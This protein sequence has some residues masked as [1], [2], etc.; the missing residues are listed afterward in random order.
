[1]GKYLPKFLGISRGFIVDSEGKESKQLDIIIFDANKAPI[2]FQNESIRVIPIECVYAIIEMKSFLRVSD[3][4]AIFKN[5]MSVRQLEKKAYIRSTENPKNTIVTGH[6][7]YD[8]EWEIWPVHYFVFALDSV[9]LENIVLALTN[10]IQNNNLQ[11]WTRIDTVGVLSKGIICNQRSN[12]TIDSLPSNES[13]IVSIKTKKALL[14]F[15]ILISTNLL[16]AEIPPL[17]LND[18]VEQVQWT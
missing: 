6:Y 10:K 5:M 13:T 14:L 17:K 4:E 9:K 15:Y 16:Q 8:R 18:Y 7:L 12:R 1:L 11:P 2:F 3:I